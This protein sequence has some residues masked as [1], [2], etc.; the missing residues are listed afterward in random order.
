[1]QL[2]SFSLPYLRAPQILRH[3]AMR[4]RLLMYCLG[5]PSDCTSIPKMSVRRTASIICAGPLNAGKQRGW[6][7]L[8]TPL[9]A[10]AGA[11]LPQGHMAQGHMPGTH[12]SMLPLELTHLC[13]RRS[14]RA[15]GSHASRSHA[16]HSLIHAAAGAPLPQGHMPGTHSSMS[17]QWG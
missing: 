5:V 4:Q 11:P 13:C 12:S 7:L 16:R 10:A 15:S 3:S 1:M 2:T 8:S 14:S 9:A 17:T 6:W